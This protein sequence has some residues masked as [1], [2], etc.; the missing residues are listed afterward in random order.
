MIVTGFQRSKLRTAVRGWG[1][2]LAITYLDNGD[3]PP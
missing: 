1:L 2:E 3:F